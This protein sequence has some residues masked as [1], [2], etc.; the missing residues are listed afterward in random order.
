ME[1][2]NNISYYNLKKFIDLSVPCQKAYRAQKEE[3]KKKKIKRIEKGFGNG[4]TDFTY[5]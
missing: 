1:G 5:F 2:D 3:N 4:F